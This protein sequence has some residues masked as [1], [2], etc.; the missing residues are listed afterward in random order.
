MRPP[1]PPRKPLKSLSRDRR[2]ATAVEYGLLVALICL[3]IMTAVRGFA[4]TAIGIWNHV[5]QV[6]D[7]SR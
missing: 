5:D 1:L 7:R 2:G 6:V 3:A 4:S